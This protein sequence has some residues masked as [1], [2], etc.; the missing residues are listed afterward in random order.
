MELASPARRALG[1]AWNAPSELLASA[2]DR[3]IQHILVDEFQG[4]SQSQLAPARAVDAGWQKRTTA[5]RCSSWR[6]ELQSIY[7]LGTP[8]LSRFLR[9]KQRCIGGFCVALTSLAPHDNF[10]SAPDMSAGINSAFVPRVS[11][12]RTDCNGVSPPSTEHRQSLAAPPAIR[13]SFAPRCCIWKKK[14]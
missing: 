7:R 2:L 9:A 11:R 6:Y 4:H 13:F 8:T 12:H 10:R 5:A 1:H 3:R 14:R